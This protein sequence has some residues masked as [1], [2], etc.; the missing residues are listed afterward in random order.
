MF[1]EFC[2]QKEILYIEKRLNCSQVLLKHKGERSERTRG[3][4]RESSWH[5]LGL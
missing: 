1:L 4:S 3:L 5:P 2:K